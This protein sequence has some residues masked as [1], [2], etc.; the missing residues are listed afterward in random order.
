[1]AQA[2]SVWIKLKAIFQAAAGW[3]ARS[4]SLSNIMALSWIIIF[5]V[6]GV[7]IA[8]DLARDVVTI[9]P[10]AVPKTLADNGYTP[11]VASHRLRDAINHYAGV[12]RAASLIEQ[13]N[14]APSDELPDFVIPQIGLSL[15]AVV[16]SIRSVLHYGSGRRISGEL[17]LHDKLA[18]RLRV[19]G[20][21]IYSSGFDAENPDDLLASAMPAVM[22]KIQPYIAALA[23]YR[24]HPEQAVEKAEDIIARSE[25]SDA[26]VQLAY[27]LK[28]NYFY[29][30]GNYAEAERWL[31]KSVRLNWSNPA[32][33]NNLGRALQR[34]TR[35]DDAVAQYQRAISINPKWAT[36]YNNLGTALQDKATPTG[37][38]DDAIVQFRRA[39]ELDRHYANPH[40]NLG[41]AY[42][43]QNNVVDAIMEYQHAIALDPKIAIF[44][45][46][47][48]NAFYHEGKTEDAIAEYRRAVE[49]D[50]KFATAHNNLGLALAS[51]GKT[52]DAIAEYRRAI[53]IYPKYA[54]AHAN[55]GMALYHQGKTEEAIAEYRRAI[56]IDPKHATAHNDL[57]LA[58]SSEGKTEDAIAEYRRAIE[59]APNYKGARENL[60]KVLQAKSAAN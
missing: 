6:I 37:K 58:L 10:I 28:G 46:N 8:Q 53:E 50:P 1:V 3:I 25:E 30:H 51:V 45:D 32:P 60:E 40:N 2:I 29:D 47:L 18:L 20:Q 38:Q 15:N 56:E 36:P 41:L 54:N 23:F 22:E 39:I 49:I 48:G 21:H 44:H 11:E 35:F 24:D 17:I 57:G 26:N 12:N 7:L 19:D 9:E 55:L 42:F 34:E 43:R 4:A 5:V 33:H 27:M 52:D 14:I 59:I 31:R 16:S 13:L